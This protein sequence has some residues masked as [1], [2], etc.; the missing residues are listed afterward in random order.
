[1]N[2]LI[3]Q[4]WHISDALWVPRRDGEPVRL[5]VARPESTVGLAR[6]LGLYPSGWHRMN[7]GR[8]RAAA[9]LIV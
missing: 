6:H 7:P 4:W 3:H 2:R 5:F 1:M 9:V 8:T